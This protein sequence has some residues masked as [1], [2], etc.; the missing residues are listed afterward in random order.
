MMREQAIQ[1]KRFSLILLALP[2]LNGCLVHTRIVKRVKMPS[3]VMTATADQLVK[4]IND[5]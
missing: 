3:V 2:L 4:V 5:R 1:Y